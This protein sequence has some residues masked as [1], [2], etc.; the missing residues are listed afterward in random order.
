MP[1]VQRICIIDS[2]S[3]DGTFQIAESLGIEIFRQP[4]ISNAAPIS[5]ILDNR[6]I[7]RD[8]VLRLDA[9]GYLEQVFS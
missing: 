7:T 6:G 1:A 2:G 3:N 9:I 4:W 8:W 5:W